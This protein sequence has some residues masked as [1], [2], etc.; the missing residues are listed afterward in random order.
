MNQGKDKFVD[1]SK[2]H[3]FDTL[4][5]AYSDRL[6][7]ADKVQLLNEYLQ[8]RRYVKRFVEICNLDQIIY[9]F[10]STNIDACDY[11]PNE[12]NITMSDQF[13][14]MLW[15]KLADHE[16]TA[17]AVE[18]AKKEPQRELV[19]KVVYPPRDRRKPSKFS[20]F[21]LVNV[22]AIILFLVILRF[23]PSR[24]GV[25]VATLIDSI[26]AKWAD[27]EGEMN[28]GTSIATGNKSLLL[29]EGYAEILFDNQAKVIL[30]GPSEFQVLSEDQIKLNYGR[31]YAIVP[32]EAIGFAIKTPSS[33][34]V[35]LGTEFGVD[36]NFQGDTSLHVMKGRTVLIAGDRA[37]KIS[38]EVTQ[39]IA[40]K[41]LIES[42]TISDIPCNDRIFVREISSADKLVWRGETK[43]DL[44]DIVGGGNGLGTGR[45]QN[46]IDPT[47]GQ[48]V[49]WKI[50]EHQYHLG[51]EE[52]V[53]VGASEYID[54]IFVPDGGEGAIRVTS[55]GNHWAGPDTSNGY[56]YNIVNSLHIPTNIDEYK[57]Y[58]YFTTPPKE[59]MILAKALEGNVSLRPMGLMAND[60]PADSSESNIF[61]HANIGIT[62]DLDRIRKLLP[63]P[64]AMKFKSTF[65]IGEITSTSARLDMWILVDGETR[66]YKQHVNQTS[67]VNLDIDLLKSDRFLTLVVTDSGDPYNF[68]Y[69]WGLFMNPRLEVN[70]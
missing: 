56:K 38:V 59:D 58:G 39:G 43:I 30:E 17:P 61:M 49:P 28:S 54:G 45:V 60:T 7:K 14:Q 37:N 4:V 20:I 26:N 10:I 62:F 47:N 63:T 70:K 34:I 11:L 23:L 68:S 15:Y 41:V 36:T 27:V 9:E 64:Y 25:E 69:D 19:Q 18:V 6:L 42:Q 52:Y 2:N 50:M 53:A 8:D 48:M 67:M 35:D 51:T 3:E 33:Q 66:L 13:D 16:K 21:T 12:K 31:L 22:A 32:R 29:R 46:S 57:D 44:A 55:L 1:P 24:G 5:F 65:G 40:K